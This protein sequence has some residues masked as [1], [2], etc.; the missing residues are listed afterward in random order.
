MMT[1]SC[2]KGFVT[3][4]TQQITARVERCPMIRKPGS[5][6]YEEEKAIIMSM[7]IRRYI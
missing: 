7:V 1:V 6:E 5:G 2:V 3:Q 4:L